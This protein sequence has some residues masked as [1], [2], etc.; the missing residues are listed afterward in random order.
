MSCLLDSSKTLK[1]LQ[2]THKDFY[3]YGLFAFLFHT[4][5]ISTKNYRELVL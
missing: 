5:Y 1:Q 3:N 4:L 2:S